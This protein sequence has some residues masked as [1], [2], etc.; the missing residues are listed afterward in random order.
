[1]K[2]INSSK[3]KLN[4]KISWFFNLEGNAPKSG[5]SPP[6][7]NLGIGIANK[8]SRLDTTSK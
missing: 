2:P 8:G 6:L 4:S 5:K 3:N 7:E 1:M